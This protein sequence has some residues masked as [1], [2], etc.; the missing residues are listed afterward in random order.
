[1]EDVA[2]A[3]AADEG[4]RALLVRC[5]QGI[6]DEGLVATCQVVADGLALRGLAVA[7]ERE[8]PEHAVA[9]S[10]MRQRWLPGQ[11]SSV[12]QRCSKSVRQPWRPSAAR[13][14]ARTT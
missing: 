4:H 5:R 12:W 13:P 11:S 8:F 1:D 14:R 2:L 6:D 3:L 9:A 10:A 7:V